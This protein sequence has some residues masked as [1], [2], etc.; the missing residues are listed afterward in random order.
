MSRRDR[1]GYLL[2]TYQNVSRARAYSCRRLWVKARADYAEVLRLC[3]DDVTALQG[4]LDTSD[5]PAVDDD[6]LLP[7][8]DVLS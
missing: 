3:T 8:A 4:V 2:L 7:D 1:S 5:P 6:R